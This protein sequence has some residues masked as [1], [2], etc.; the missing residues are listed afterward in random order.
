MYLIP[1][2]DVHVWSMNSNEVPLKSSQLCSCLFN[3]V[4][5]HPAE[6]VGNTLSAL[7]WCWC[8]LCVTAWH[9]VT[10]SSIYI[11]YQINR[12]KGSNCIC[13]YN[14][15]NH[16]QT[17]QIRAWIFE[18]IFM[19]RRT[20]MSFEN[21]FDL[22]PSVI[23]KIIITIGI[24]L[25]RGVFSLFWVWGCLMKYPFTLS[26]RSNIMISWYRHIHHLT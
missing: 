5:S 19:A 6:R 7:E 4:T 15:S 1:R 26:I 25:P 22:F 20:L 9:A 10:W 13:Y 2:Q 11:G 18:V 12:K 24:A 3:T 8:T 16:F 17:L 21:I 14:K 23:S